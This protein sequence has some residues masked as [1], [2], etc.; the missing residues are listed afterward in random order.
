MKLNKIKS[1]ICGMVNDRFELKN[2]AEFEEELL[3][4]SDEDL[5]QK[6]ILRIKRLGIEVDTWKTIL[7]IEIEAGD[8]KKRKEE[9][10]KAIS[11]L[12]LVK[13][14][15]LGDEN[16]DLYLFLAFSGKISIEECL[17]IEATEQ[18]CRKYVLMPKEEISDFLNR[19]FLQKL[20]NSTETIGCE[21]PL[22]R[23]FSKTAALY[24]WLT[25][26]IQK[27]WKKYFK[28]LSGS[29]LVEALVNEED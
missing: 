1:E 18:F 12:A 9:L 21:D 25:P 10:K 28:E 14:S 13:E 22:E 19:T 5:T 23:A 2:N 16:I 15:L 6:D 4:L 27:K 26:E 7:L 24:S 11:W 29:D 3:F 17:R 8:E 20:V